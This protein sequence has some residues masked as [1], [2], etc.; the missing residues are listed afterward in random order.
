M[1][2]ELIL[3]VCYSRND[4]TS[5]LQQSL[6]ITPLPP[7]VPPQ[8]GF[9]FIGKKDIVNDE[10]DKD[11]GEYPGGKLF[12]GV[13]TFHNKGKRDGHERNIFY[14]CTVTG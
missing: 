10:Q 5:E 14:Q 8:I 12:A 2:R 7:G 3:W 13:S 9:I 6:K 4:Q 1:K 11:C